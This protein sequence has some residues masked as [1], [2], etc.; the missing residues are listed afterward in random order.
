M[1]PKHGFQ[2]WNGDINMFYKHVF[3]KLKTHIYVF[4]G[5]FRNRY[6]MMLQCWNENPDARPYFGDIV[7]RLQ[8]ML[9]DSQVM[10]FAEI[11][12][13][14]TVRKIFLTTKRHKTVHLKAMLFTL[15]VYM[16]LDVNE[17]NHYAEIK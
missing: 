14:K 11:Q 4:A 15:Q 5:G 13:S 9:E 2:F 1:F 6:A 10:I 12:I 7:L 8:R 3:C 16:N 17:G